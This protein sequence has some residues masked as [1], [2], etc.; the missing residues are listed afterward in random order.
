MKNSSRHNPTKDV[1]APS[2]QT[3]Q[4]PANRAGTNTH[5]SPKSDSGVM[6]RHPEL[7]FAI[8]QVGIRPATRIIAK[9]AESTPLRAAKGDDDIMSQEKPL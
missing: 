4:W 6:L 9:P 7:P 2:K 8:Q 1:A 3:Q 5:P